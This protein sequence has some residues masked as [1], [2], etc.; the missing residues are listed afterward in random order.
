MFAKS[1]AVKRQDFL[2]KQKTM[3]G[4]FCEYLAMSSG[5]LVAMIRSRAQYRTEDKSSYFSL[6]APSAPKSFPL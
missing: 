4:F 5:S 3:M 6:Q 1:L 2:V